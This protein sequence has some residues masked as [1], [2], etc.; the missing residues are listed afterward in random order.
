LVYGDILEKYAA[1]SEN[2]SVA[3]EAALREPLQKFELGLGTVLVDRRKMMY[4]NVLV[5]CV[6]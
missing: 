2:V 5:Y 4:V 1:F 3:Y 6:S